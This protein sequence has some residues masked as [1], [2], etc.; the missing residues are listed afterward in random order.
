MTM[1]GLEVLMPDE[2]QDV[3]ERIIDEAQRLSATCVSR[4]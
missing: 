2:L 4:T 3:I 1:A